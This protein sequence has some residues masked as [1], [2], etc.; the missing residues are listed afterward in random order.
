M[1]KPQVNFEEQA[2]MLTMPPKKTKKPVDD[3]VMEPWIELV[4]GG[5]FY[6]NKPTWDIGA[7]AHSLSLQCRFTGQCKKFYSVA[8]HSVLVSRIMEDLGLGDP[9]E[10]LMHDAVE[11]VLSD[12]ARPAKNLLKDYK[13]LD[14]ALDATMRKQFLLPEVMTDGCAKAD[15]IALLIEAKALLPGKGENFTGMSD[16]VILAARKAT[17][18]VVGWTSE[19]ARG[20][21]M[22]RMHDIRR[23]LRGL[24]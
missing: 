12:V 18:M 19:D 14:K 4:T 13:A 2:P 3:D 7:I 9:M 5:K 1:N 16:E 15:G 8:E 23:R 10:G 24:R 17:Y 11:S 22:T 20:R 6:Y 21:F